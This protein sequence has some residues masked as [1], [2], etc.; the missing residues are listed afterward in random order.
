MV[1]KTFSSSEFIVLFCATG[2]EF[3]VKQ[4]YTLY[5]HTTY[6]LFVSSV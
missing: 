6:A 3:E 5:I 4:G 1:Q 2:G